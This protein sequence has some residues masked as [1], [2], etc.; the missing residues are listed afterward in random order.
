MDAQERREQTVAAREDARARVRFRDLD[1]DRLIAD[2]TT[3]VHP[4]YI[5]RQGPFTL[6]HLARFPA[7]N[8]SFIPTLDLLTRLQVEK[9]MPRSPYNR[10]RELFETD[11][12][13]G[14]RIPRTFDTE[15]QAREALF[16]WRDCLFGW[17]LDDVLDAV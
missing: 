13:S 11:H 12:E 16:Q 2:P 15:D 7:N 1:Y 4:G 9:E 5:V 17:L 10:Y 14:A 3:G 8:W 6:G